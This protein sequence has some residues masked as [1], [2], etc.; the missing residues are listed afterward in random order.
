RPDAGLGLRQ[1]TRPCAER[2][3]PS[4]WRRSF[5]L[6]PSSSRTARRNFKGGNGVNGQRVVRHALENNREI[7]A[8]GCPA[9]RQGIAAAPTRGRGLVVPLQHLFDLFPG[10]AVAFD[11]DVPVVA[12]GVVFQV[13]DE[14]HLAHTHV[15]PLLVI[16]YKKGAKDQQTA[17]I[18]SS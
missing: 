5:F 15:S 7:L 3:F 2:D 16:K 1:S 11:A 18:S 4:S 17:A 13:P 8:A 14:G 9:Q 12:L 10:N 6:S